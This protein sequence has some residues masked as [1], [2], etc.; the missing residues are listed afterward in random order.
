MC[1]M[2]LDVLVCAG[3]YMYGYVLS[4][5]GICIFAQV[6]RVFRRPT[7]YSRVHIAHAFYDGTAQLRESLQ[8]HTF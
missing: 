4:C 6:R 8:G 2:Y 7:R 3:V 1:W 5:A